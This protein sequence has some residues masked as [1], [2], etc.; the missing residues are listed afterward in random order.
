MDY[1][2]CK[3]DKNQAQ[4]DIS[5]SNLLDIKNLEKSLKNKELIDN[6]E[7]KSNEKQNISNY[8]LEIIEYPYSK[9]EINNYKN[10][11]N[12]YNENQ[13]KTKINK[14]NNQIV[15]S[16]KMNMINKNDYLFNNN[17]IIQNK[18]LCSKGDLN[19]SLN[20]ESLI[21]EEE[22]N[23]LNDDDTQ[24]EKTEKNNIKKSIKKKENDNSKKKLNK[25]YLQLNNNNKQKL[26]VNKLHY[27]TCYNNT[28][29]RGSYKARTN[30]ESMKSWTTKVST[31]NNSRKINTYNKITSLSIKKLNKK[32][33]QNTINYIE[34][35]TSQGKKSINKN[36]LHTFKEN[37]IIAQID[38]FSNGLFTIKYNEVVKAK[39]KELII[40]INDL[41]ETEYTY[42]SNIIKRNFYN[43]VSEIK[44]DYD[45]KEIKKNNYRFSVEYFKIS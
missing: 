37:S 5:L 33:L 35:P 42:L 45:R 18:I 39:I 29:G 4:E 21:V 43:V 30:N 19:S 15:N 41:T 34:T 11:K 27:F 40:N 3:C 31:L 22:I 7:R 26:V 12:Y 23:Y 16:L 44:Y 28:S 38:P 1:L 10:Y 32:F 25:L 24:T 14:D 13:K 8:E 9:K 36:I 17:K 2:V 20:N 6:L